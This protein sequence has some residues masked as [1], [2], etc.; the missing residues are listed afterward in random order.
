[1]LGSGPRVAG[2]SVPAV[3]VTDTVTQTHSLMPLLDERHLR[4]A[5]RDCMRRSSSPGM[6]GM[7]WAGYRDGF[8]LRIAELADRLR[9]GIWLPAPLRTAT[10]PSYVDKQLQVVVPTVEDR[11]VHRA[12]R[13]A[14]EPILEAYAYPPCGRQGGAG[15]ATGSTRFGWPPASSSRA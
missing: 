11:I 2:G 12:L 8:P 15:D 13:A 7:T 5:A 6:D 14:I 10:F 9:T 4:R 1:M 3:Q